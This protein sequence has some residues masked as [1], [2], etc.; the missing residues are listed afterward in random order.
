V[1]RVER[2]QD[3]ATVT[4]DA[5]ATKNA[6]TGEM[7]VALGAAFKDLSWSGV[8]AIV[9]TGAGED[10][11]SG[12]DLRSGRGRGPS[13]PGDGGDA[14]GRLPESNLHNMRVLADAVLSIHACPVPTI[15]K[16]DG[17]CVGAG[18]GVALSADL[19][20]CSDRAR[21]SLIFAKRGLSLDFGTSWL[22]RQRIG[23]HKAKE[24]AFTA[25]MLSGAEA[26]D[27]G[28]VNAV[29]P[30]AELDDAVAELAATI[31]AGPP[32]ALS[33]SKRQLDNAATSSL[34]H[35]LEVEALSQTVNAATGDLREAMTAWSERRPPNFT[36]S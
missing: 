2:E 35:A 16:I 20:W 31:A 9:L 23:V 12:A 33:M 1:I 7:W 13:E 30:A 6:C 28:F 25:R 29:V 4:I 14:A 21:F 19:A 24:M 27:I 3:V 15:A 17:L 5:P 8:R 34:A 26:H 11:C 22:L 10:F 32:L 18:L 36:G